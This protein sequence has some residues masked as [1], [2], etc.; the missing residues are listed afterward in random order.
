MTKR[1]NQH[2]VPRFYLKNFS[3]SKKT[4]DIYNI[5]NREIIIG[6]K[7][8]TQCYEPYFYGKDGEIEKILSEIDEKASLIIRN[9]IAG[10][11]VP[12]RFSAEHV[13]LLFYILA[14]MGRTKSAADEMNKTAD[15]IFKETFRDHPK[16]KNL[17]I[18][19]V[20]LKLTSAPTESLSIT[21]S[22]LPFVL[23]LGMKILV[24]YT[25]RY[26]ITSDN[27]VVICNQYLGQQDEYG[28][29]GFALRG[30]QII[31]PL[32]P[33]ISI[34]FFDEDVYR[35]GN[36]KSIEVDITS[37]AEIG[38][39]NEMQW[40]N[41]LENIYYPEDTK[42][43]TIKEDEK[44][45]LVQKTQKQITQI[46]TTFNQEDKTQ[47]KFFKLGK[48]SI[49]VGYRPRYIKIR[50]RWREIHPNKRN[51]EVR[52]PELHL[53][54]REFCEKNEGANNDLK[55]FFEFLDDYYNKNCDKS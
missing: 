35:V 50:R 5:S 2:Y 52:D 31:F 13:N 38:K 17:D 39:L 22:G 40:A 9:V 36:K 10:T 42:I 19:L 16:L 18:D 33:S 25:N 32:N 4:I 1:K 3:A 26:F 47:S 12:Q 54:Y 53:A 8:K 46:Q 21:I 55:K 29:G 28:T 6:A 7:L 30:T 51:I 24:N 41:A 45:F 44:K 15:Y 49:D 37:D 27:P 14:Q 43:G 48:R 34:I 23:D 20:T 11:S